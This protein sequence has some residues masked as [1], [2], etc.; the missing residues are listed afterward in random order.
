[1]DRK[2]ELLLKCFQK[3][4]DNPGDHEAF[5]NWLACLFLI[6]PEL[7]KMP[8][9][10]QGLKKICKKLK[11][12]IIEEVGFSSFKGLCVSSN[13]NISLGQKN[14]ILAEGDKAKLISDSLWKSLSK[15]V[16]ESGYAIV[17]EKGLPRLYKVFTLAHEVGHM[18]LDHHLFSDSSF[19]NIKEF[20][21]DFFAYVVTDIFPEYLDCQGKSVFSRLKE[22]W[23][24]NFYLPIK[25][26]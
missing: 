11:V 22:L 12:K 17:L 21:A 7:N 20:Q 10:W 26:L 15:S 3:Y 5:L 1:M 18:L 8:L 6:Y 4:Q 9:S 2:T 19:Y 23:L 16:K 13:I 24:Q 14:N 25:K